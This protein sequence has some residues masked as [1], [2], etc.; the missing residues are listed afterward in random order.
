MLSCPVEW[1]LIQSSIHLLLPKVCIFLKKLN[2]TF[3][4]GVLYTYNWNLINC[5][6]EKAVCSE[7]AFRYSREFYLSHFFRNMRPPVASNK[8][9]AKNFNAETNVKTIRNS[10][11]VQRVAHHKSPLTAATISK[12]QTIPYSWCS[13]LLQVSA[14][15][16]SNHQA[17]V[18][19]TQ[20]NVKDRIFSLQS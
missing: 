3:L 15:Q 6:N 18:G 20:W 7:S 4:C 8:A 2:F 12:T 11:P 14:V 19:Y 17:E 5:W 10:T 1:A 9:M 16:I 13:S